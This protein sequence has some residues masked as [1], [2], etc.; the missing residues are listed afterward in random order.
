M[1]IRFHFLWV[2]L[3]GS[4]AGAARAEDWAAALARMPLGS[5]VTWLTR[6]N[7]AQ[8]IF[9]ALSADTTVKA[10]VFMPGAT[11]ELYFFHRVN[12]QL[13]NPQPTLRDALQALTNQSP[14]RV[15]FRAPLLLVYSEEDVLDLEIKVEHP[16]TV[17]KLKRAVIPGRQEFFDRDWKA[18][19]DHHLRKMSA[20]ISPLNRFSITR[21]FYRHTYAGWNLTAWE[22]LQATASAGKTRFTVRRNHVEFDLDERIGGV[23]RL[24]KFPD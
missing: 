6:T 19:R 4:L 8:A 2:L 14:L 15:T 16:A 7:C 18:V 12:V 9:Q 17:E 5:N 20:G 22:T 10:I 24:E 1:R 11:D 21:H 3:L 23:P 13:T